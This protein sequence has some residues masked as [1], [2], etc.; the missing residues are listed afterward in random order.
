MQFLKHLEFGIL[1]KQRWKRLRWNI[2]KYRV[3][4]SA[5]SQEEKKEDEL[6][7]GCKYHADARNKNGVEIILV[8][9]LE[10]D[11]HYADEVQSTSSE[12]SI[13]RSHSRR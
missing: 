11:L 13:C 3:V 1:A 4:C 5:G 9:A 10:A 8:A 7:G 6:G 2:E 12:Q